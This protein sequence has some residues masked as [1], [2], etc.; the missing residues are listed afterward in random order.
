MRRGTRDRSEDGT[1]G[2]GAGSGA[3]DAP[4]RRRRGLPPALWPAALLLALA[5][6]GPWLAPHDPLAT[7]MAASLRPPSA[8]HWFGT[9]TLGRDVFSRVLA[10][11]RLDL[12]MA[13]A[14]VAL[15]ALPG[16]ALGA[17]CGLRGGWPDRAVGRLSDA[18]MAFPLFVVALALAAVL[19]NSVGSVVLATAA[20]NLPFYLRLARTEVAARRGAAYVQAARLAGLGGAALLRR[21]LL[22]NALPV[23]AVQASTN[24]G[25]A[26][27]NGAG[28][29]F[30]GLGVRPPTPE[31]GVLVSEGAQVLLAGQWWVGAFP[32]LA[33]FGAVYAFALAGDALR[34]RLDPRRRP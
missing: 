9:D 19:G 14:A 10:A 23:L 5:V 2:P 21:V 16:I 18:L 26:I 33:L 17:A 30:L 29:S 11:A 7:D 13:V 8:A 22:P 1:D 28:L 24:L 3:A 15:S 6:A 34:D 27:L 12:A 4:R 20:I 31:W 32:G 25:W